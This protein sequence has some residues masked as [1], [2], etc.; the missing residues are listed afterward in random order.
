MPYTAAAI[1]TAERLARIE[2]G[3]D[4]IRRSQAKSCLTLNGLIAGVHRI[5]VECSARDTRIT[6]AEGEIETLREEG[7]ARTREQRLWDVLNTVAAA[8]GFVVGGQK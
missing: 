2:A 7:R 1:E 4:E 8:A 3:I 5:E 6:A